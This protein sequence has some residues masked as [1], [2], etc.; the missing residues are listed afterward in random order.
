MYLDGDDVSQAIREH[1]V[2][3]YASQVSAVPQVREYLLELQRELARR[4]DVIMDGRDIGT[5]VLP[6]ADVKIYLTAAPE[7][8]A[9]R[10]FRELQERGQQTDQSTVLRDI[11]RRDEQDMNRDTAPL[12]QAEDAVLVDTTQLDL[13][14]SLQAILKIIREKL[15]L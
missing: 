11:L 12:R 9:R 5:V 7:A 15:A 14:Q 4:H 1:A 8:R 10:R 2:S 6:G 3:Q 13:E